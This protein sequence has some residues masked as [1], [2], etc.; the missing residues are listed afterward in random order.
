MEA[1]SEAFFL[2][3]HAGGFDKGF[4][5]QGLGLGIRV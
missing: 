1:S 2:A 3:S 4:R 5:V